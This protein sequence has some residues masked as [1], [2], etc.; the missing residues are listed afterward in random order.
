MNS[1]PLSREPLPPRLSMNEY[2]DF[3][4]ELIRDGDPAMM[5]RQKAIEEQITKPF[6]IP[7]ARVRENSSASRHN[8]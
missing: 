8:D 5:T 7:A 1:Q 3:V 2:A 6:R 4:W